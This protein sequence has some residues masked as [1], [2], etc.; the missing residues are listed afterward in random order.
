MQ[1]LSTPPTRGLQGVLYWD[2]LLHLQIRN[3]SKRAFE[4]P[5]A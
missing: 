2:Y 4:G 1:K 5:F 3:N